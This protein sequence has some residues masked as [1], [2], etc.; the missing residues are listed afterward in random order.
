[1]G[2]ELVMMRSW[3]IPY[4]R[5]RGDP[6]ISPEELERDLL[7]PL[8]TYR[9]LA[10][11]LTI[12]TQ[13]FY[14]RD[15]IFWLLGYVLSNL[16][17]DIFQTIVAMKTTFLCF[18]SIGG[19]CRVIEPGAVITLNKILKLRDAEIIGIIAHELGHLASGSLFGNFEGEDDKKAD[20]EALADELAI[21][22]GFIDEIE[23]IRKYFKTK[24]V[25]E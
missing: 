6:L 25:K 20:K 10:R 2:E 4:L 5:E 13:R 21:S 18:D 1:L 11:C 16:P 3:V 14:D 8:L 22:W 24:E 19:I 15:R 9:R 7:I 12:I 17:Q 23:A